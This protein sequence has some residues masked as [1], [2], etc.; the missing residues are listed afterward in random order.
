MKASFW[1]D[2]RAPN[3]AAH[4]DLHSHPSVVALI[5][6]SLHHYRDH[7]AFTGIGH[8]LTFA[9]VDRLSAQFASYLQHHTHLQPGDRIAIQM[10]N[11]LQYPIVA[12]GALR[13]G[14][15]IVN[16]N[17]LYTVREM[18][19]QFQDA[20]V[21]ALIFL[22][23][24][25]HLVEEAIKEVPV[26]LLIM[27]CLADMLPTPK[28]QIINFTAKHIKKMVPRYQLKSVVPLLSALNMG[29]RAAPY[30]P[31]PVDRNDI[32]A[33][34]YT[35]GTTGVA[36]GAMLTHSNLLANALQA[37]AMLM[38]TDDNGELILKEG[39]QIIIA[40]LPLY[41]IYAF[42]VHLLCMPYLGNHSVLIANPRDTDTFIKFI[43][44][45]Q[46]T[47]FVGLN[48]LFVSLMNHPLF[49][50]C[51]FKRL[52]LT[53]SGGTALQ[54]AVAHRWHDITGC[55][56]SEA[57][58]L[59]ET[60]PAVTMNPAGELTQQ[61]TV[62]VAVPDTVLK[63][64]DETGEETPLGNPGELCIKGPQVMKGYWQNEQ[65][66]NEVLDTDGWLHTG[67]IAIIEADGFVRIVDRLKDMILVSGFNVYP[68]EIEDIFA[69]H[70]GIESCAAIGVTDPVTG[71]K[72]KLFA[73]RTDSSLTE[74]ALIE[75]GREHLTAYKVPT[76]VEFRDSLPMTPV[77]KILRK[78][79]R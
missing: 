37:R 3:I 63:T 39:E 70:P 20:G 21:K 75:W 69:Q 50:Q 62:G 56:I 23:H 19:H 66:T 58:G 54:E 33:L 7:S 34:Q 13:A 43:K 74:E 16:T 57:Y 73:V 4:I 61:G 30:T 42:T 41:H 18:V 67:D 53:F 9:D 45:W 1:D 27:T 8:T 71:E 78:D 36:K 60:S 46:F 14:L 65:A 68:N 2:K 77:G 10:P 51:N 49:T 31:V 15:V 12:Y 59:T 28:R 64:V 79:L 52:K 6:E 26:E 25:A 38:Q 76:Y 24:F 11:L 35:G 5:N 55:T 32:V 48:T 17:P 44:P 22:D 29:R 47:A 40:P 72:V